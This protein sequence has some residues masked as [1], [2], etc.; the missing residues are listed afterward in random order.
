MLRLAE[1]RLL[2]GLELASPVQLS[3]A[4]LRGRKASATRWTTLA[5]QRGAA[6]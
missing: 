2:A 5:K 3:P 6:G 1:Q 4:Q